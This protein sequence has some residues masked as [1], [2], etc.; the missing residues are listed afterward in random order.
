MVR[1]KDLL[2]A[3]GHI[4][5]FYTKYF[6]YIARKWN[7]K[8]ALF[9]V[10]NDI[11]GEKKYRINTSEISDL[12]KLEITGD[13]ARHADIYMGS[14]YFLLEKCFEEIKKYNKRSFVDFGSGKGRVLVVA[15]HYNFTKITGI[16]F[17]KELCDIAKDNIA[18]NQSYFPDTLWRVFHM[19]AIAYEIEDGDE[20]FF[21]YSPF[22]P[23]IMRAVIKNILKSIEKT[24]REIFII[25]VFPQMKEFFL[26]AGFS[27]I[28]SFKKMETEEVSILKNA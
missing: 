1:L 12:K 22:G 11:K 16:E 20:V 17:A 28:Y 26:K 27:E 2:Y 9:T 4:N 6:I 3:L 23:N 19:D 8:L 18:N 24:P 21:F 14:N 13:N 10:V 7:S 5:L 15:A 25:Y